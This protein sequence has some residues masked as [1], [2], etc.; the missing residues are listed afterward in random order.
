[1]PLR[2]FQHAFFWLLHRAGPPDPGVARLATFGLHA[3]A[4]VLV[5]ILARQLG[6]SRHGAFCALALFA[7]F[8]NVKTLVWVA[9]VSG[10]GR[11][12]CVLAGLCCVLR[13]RRAPSWWTGPGLL[14]ALLAGLCF[15]QA[16]F[17]LPAFA[18]LAAIA[19]DRS[20]RGLRS[21]LAGALRDPCLIAG[22]LVAIVY[23]GYIVLLR[24][25]RHH[26]VSTNAAALAANFAKAA[27]ALLPEALRAPALVGLR[28][29]SGMAGSLLGYG[30][31]AAVLAGSAILFAR[32]TAVQ[33]FLLL[34]IALD[35][36]LPAITS[37]FVG[38]YCHLPSALAACWVALAAPRRA[39]LAAIGLLAAAWTFDTVADVREYRSAGAEVVRIL[40]AARDVRERSPAGRPIALVDPPAAWGRERD[41]PMFNW[42]LREALALRGVPG[43]W[44][45]YRT[46]Q[47]YMLTDAEPLTG[48][49]LA[50]M[51]RSSPD[52]LVIY[53]ST[54][55]RIV[56]EQ[57]AR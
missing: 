15:H 56:V 41:I 49:Q 4:G 57:P 12:V 6:C 29:Q 55:G 24:E 18:V 38:R 51:R 23:V 26:K 8:P 45:L 27:L 42:G 40:E 3:I 7:V 1:V 13:H 31:V 44:R 33:R 11:V 53:D 16:T 52:P 43:P 50:A 17:L 32:S 28:G 37:G 22:L 34:A 9:A 25:E 14:I 19:V 48:D 20:P 36:A 47:T 39:W 46:E 5:A 2:P 54:T 30:T 10:P 21:R 35:L